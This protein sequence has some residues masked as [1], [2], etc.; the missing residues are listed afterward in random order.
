[1]HVG[2][3]FTLFK[4]SLARFLHRFAVSALSPQ[5]CP[6]F[7][8][9]VCMPGTDPCIQTRLDKKWMPQNENFL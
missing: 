8:T 2:T 1:M 4:T 3:D 6:F 5:N 9:G 7:C